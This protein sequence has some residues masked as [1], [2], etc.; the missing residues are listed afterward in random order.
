[1]A[2]GGGAPQTGSALPIYVI[3]RDEA[4][5]P[6]PLAEAKLTGWRYPIVGAEPGLASLA[7][8]AEQPHFAGISHGTLPQRVLDAATLAEAVLGSEVEH[9]EPRLLEIPALRI[10]CLWFK[11]EQTDRF[12]SLMDGQPPGTEPLTI[13]QEIVPRIKSALSRS[14]LS[15][16]PPGGLRST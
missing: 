15:S 14:T 4:G 6:D 16:P 8:D 9:F 2:L 10:Y 12:I 11:G 7:G 13:E 1:M 5:T 3:T